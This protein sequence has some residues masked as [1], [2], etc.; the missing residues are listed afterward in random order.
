MVLFA[1]AVSTGLNA[2]SASDPFIVR[3][4]KKLYM[5]SIL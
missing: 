1:D 4:I 2:S 3:Q 5:V